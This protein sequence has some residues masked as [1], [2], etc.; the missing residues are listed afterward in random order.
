VLGVVGGPLPGG[1]AREH[2]LLE[3]VITVN[4]GVTDDNVFMLIN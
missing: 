2:H 3:E 4:K 1:G